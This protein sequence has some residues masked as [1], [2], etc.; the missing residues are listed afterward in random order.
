MV[1]MRILG[2]KDG[3]AEDASPF[4]REHKRALSAISLATP[5]AVHRRDPRQ[6]GRMRRKS[7]LNHRKPTAGAR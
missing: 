6:D 4:L 7:H 2:T 5:V 1:C 3:V